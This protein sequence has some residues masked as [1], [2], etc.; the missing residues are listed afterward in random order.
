MEAAALKGVENGRLGMAEKVW[1]IT[2][3]SRG[4]GKVIL[5]AA[6]E[7]GDCA[8][9]AS[10]SINH[11]KENSVREDRLLRVAL[12]ITD[13]EQAKAA[14]SAAV[15]RFGRI[16]VLVNN[17]GF[18]FLGYFEELTPDEV[19]TQ[20]ETNVFGT[21]NVLRAALPIMRKQHAGRVFNFSSIG[22]VSGFEGSAIYSASKFAIEGVSEALVKELDQF[23]IKVT[24]IEPG[25]FRTD[26]LDSSS[27]R[28]GSLRVDDYREKSEAR[29]SFIRDRNH[30]QN[31]DPAKLAA[32]IMRLADAPEPPLRFL[33]GSDAI[34]TAEKVWR[35]RLTL[36]EQWRALSLSTD[37]AGAEQ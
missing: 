20:F 16:D 21:M 24:I 32:A 10:R 18:G 23:G 3:A 35:D 15:E 2:G 9:A 5:D 36:L 30:M 37:L 29:Q 4:F 27:V 7:K 13:A 19:R 33:G 8:V 26:F 22:G 12:D 6:L 31:G 34:E 1:F 28:Y 17:A 25:Y 14:V 11:G